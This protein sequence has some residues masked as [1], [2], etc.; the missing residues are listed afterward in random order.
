MTADA[1]VRISRTLICASVTVRAAVQLALTDCILTSANGTFAGPAFRVAGYSRTSG[2]LSLSL[3]RNRFVALFHLARS[4]NGS[5]NRTFP[6]SSL[7]MEL[8]ALLQTESMQR[9][10]NALT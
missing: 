8:I 5:P 3:T 10:R 1:F 4:V 6:I 9:N 7:K 2:G